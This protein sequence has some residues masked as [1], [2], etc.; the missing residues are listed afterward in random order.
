ML[1]VVEGA[2]KARALPGFWDRS[3][4]LSFPTPSPTVEWWGQV[5]LW[6]LQALW[7]FLSTGAPSAFGR[8]RGLWVLWGQAWKGR[9]GRKLGL[10]GVL[11]PQLE[12]ALGAVA[13]HLLGS[14]YLG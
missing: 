8:T 13:S 10:G 6:V 3:G 4:H 12:G 11:A 2:G 7:L 14:G 1:H 5:T 9:G